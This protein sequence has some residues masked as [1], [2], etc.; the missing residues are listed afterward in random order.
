[1]LLNDYSSVS[2]TQW[3]YTGYF[4]SLIRILVIV[5]VFFN[6]LG[7]VYWLKLRYNTYLY[8]IRKQYFLNNNTLQ[9]KSQDSFYKYQVSLL[10]RIWMSLTALVTNDDS[11]IFLYSILY[12]VLARYISESFYAV[13]LAMI[14]S[15]YSKVI[16]LIRSVISKN[17]VPLLISFIFMMFF[18]CFFTFN[19]MY[20]NQRPFVGK[21]F[22]LFVG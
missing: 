15:R 20:M 3:F 22:V 2:L 13:Q 11:N 6:F 19:M 1:M 18:C 12:L 21:S 4:N 7:Y 8:T 5:Q 14:M 9:M 10:R 17:T 16:S